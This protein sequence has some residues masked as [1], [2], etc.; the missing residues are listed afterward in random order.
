MQLKVRLAEIELAT[1][2]RISLQ[3][4]KVKL[5]TETMG[6]QA[7]F[8]LSGKDG[9]GPEVATPPDEPPGRAPDGEAFQ[10]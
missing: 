4:A 1:Q 5:A 6:I 7:Q 10:A 9:K 2:E 8:A 3:D